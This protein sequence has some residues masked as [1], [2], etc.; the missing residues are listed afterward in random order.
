VEAYYTS[1]GFMLPSF[2]RFY[3]MG[4]QSSIG[5]WPKFTWVSAAACPACLPA[6]LPGDLVTWQGSCAQEQLPYLVSLPWLP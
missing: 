1:S 6:C 3:W 4:L 2:H 5:A